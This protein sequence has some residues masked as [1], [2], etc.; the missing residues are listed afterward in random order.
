MFSPPAA[1]L[2]V[3]IG[4][5][6]SCQGNAGWHF[7]GFLLETRSPDGAWRGGDCRAQM[8][9]KSL[10]E[11][12]RGGVCSGTRG[13]KDQRCAESWQNPQTRVGSRRTLPHAGG[14]RI[15]RPYV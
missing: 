11:A 4:F 15:H 5:Q 12:D 10:Q 6:Q 9:G 2:P 8:V 3:P 13:L 1:A 7:L 14:R